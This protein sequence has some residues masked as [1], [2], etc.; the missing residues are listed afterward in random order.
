MFQKSHIFFFKIRSI[1]SC[2]F[3]AVQICAPHVRACMHTPTPHKSL[4]GFT[5]FNNRDAEPYCVLMYRLNEKQQVKHPLK[6]YSFQKHRASVWGRTVSRL[7]RKGGPTYSTPMMDRLMHIML[8]YLIRYVIYY[9]LVPPTHNLR[10]VLV[11]ETRPDRTT[12]AIP[13]E[14]I[15]RALFNFFIARFVGARGNS[16]ARRRRPLHDLGSRTP[17]EDLIQ[18]LR[19]RSRSTEH[20]PTRATR[21]TDCELEYVVESWFSMHP[22]HPTLTCMHARPRAGSVSVFLL[23]HIVAGR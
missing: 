5:C 22:P 12:A 7:K 23:V 19:S 14:Q 20:L 1:A 2:V 16:P 18:L 15:L 8:W 21:L 13:T 10:P 3:P 17:H 4:F 11:V 9:S 6:K